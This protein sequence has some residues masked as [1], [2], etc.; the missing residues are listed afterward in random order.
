[1]A[2]QPTHARRVN[3]GRSSSAAAVLD[4]PESHV[5]ATKSGSKVQEEILRLVDASRA[6]RLSER[7]RPDRLEGNDRKVIEGVNLMLDAILIPIGEVNRVLTQISSGKIDELITDSYTGDH[8]KMKQAVNNVGGALQGMQKELA[9]LVVAAKE[10]QLAERTKPE[11]FHGVYADIVRGVNE[12]LDAILL[13]IGE[14]NR[15]LAQI[16]TGKVDELIVQS[17][18]GDHEKMKQAVNQVALV[19]QGMQKELARLV[20]ASREGQLSERGKA[21]RFEG[22]YAG[23]VNGVNEMLDAI[24]LPIGEGNRILALLRGG[25]L[26]EKVQI[27]CKGDHDKMKQ[28]VNGVHDWLQDLIAFVTKIANGDLTA[29]I[30]KA[31]DQ[32]QIHEWLVLLKSN[33][34]GLVTD[35][36]VLARAAADGRVGARADATKHQGDY[37]K[38]VE[39]INAT[40]EA[41]VEP[42]RITAQNASTLASSSEELTA[43]S[44][45]MAGNAEETATQANVVSAASEEV[46]KN[47][48][49]V[50]SA[51]EQMQASIRE[52]SKN[53][54]ESARVAK[55]AVS[56]A[57]ST[58]ETV[59]KLGESS[60]EIGNVIKVITSIA[61]QTNLLALNA[62][63]EAARAGEAG[64]GFAVVA[65]EVK[66]LAKQT[67]KATEDIGQ[68]I[69]AIQG[70]T[71]GAVKAIEEIGTIINQI[72]DI[73]NSIASAVEEQTVTTNEIGRSVNEA[74]K[75]VDDIAKNIGGVA[76]AAKNTTQGANDTQKASQELS[77]MAIRLQTV[78]SKF[79]F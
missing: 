68:K 12:T 76:V 70:D 36:T 71:K 65:N 54:N 35:A 11:L 14:G 19:L 69:D 32:D 58:N 9:R 16:S 53:A 37:R 15:V 66:E 33:I 8:E 18:R 74:A 51:S 77:Q 78:M 31:S 5:T 17:Y 3:S 75:G 7:G 22:A 55:N 62:T 72:N 57:H 45:Q 61:Q 64:K 34:S 10:G 43:V 30:A 28:A 79:T 52:I 39:S 38:I 41:I 47:V 67:A 44:Q 6:G 26:R 56:V 50:A 42:L 63:I 21:E 1:M 2:S 24:L 49:S 59:K 25:N 46:S 27:A 29:S 48:A 60:Q 13:P 20:V 40:L 23:I 4:P 73:S